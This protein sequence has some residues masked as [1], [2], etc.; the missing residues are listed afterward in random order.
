[1][2]KQLKNRHRK[3]IIVSVVVLLVIVFVFYMFWRNNKSSTSIATAGQSSQQTVKGSPSTPTQH[4]PTTNNNSIQGG[5]IDHNGEVSDSLPPSSQWVSSSSGNITLQEPL[6]NTTLKS[7]DTLSGIAK[8]STV[9]F[10]LTDNSV[11]LVAQG[12]LSV[13][14]GKFSGVL[15]FIPHSSSGKLEIYYPNPINGAEEDIIDIDVN[16]SI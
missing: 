9:Q 12:N 1:M 8:V 5:V 4:Q 7:G 6:T 10:I 13:V 3:S 16:F 14:N 2:Y 15:Q 11:G